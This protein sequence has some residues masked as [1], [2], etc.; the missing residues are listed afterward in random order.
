LGK[1]EVDVEIF[2]FGCRVAGIVGFAGQVD[3]GTDVPA[4][5]GMEFIP[6]NEFRINR[7]IFSG[8]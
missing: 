3:D 6:G 4:G 7:I 8:L 5:Q 2:L 1:T